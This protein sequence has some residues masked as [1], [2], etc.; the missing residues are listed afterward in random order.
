MVFSIQ[1]HQYKCK[2]FRYFVLFK[3]LV[4]DTNTLFTSR[5]ILCIDS[6]TF[7]FLHFQKTGYKN[8]PHNLWKHSQL[9]IKLIKALK[10]H[11][12]SEV[13][14]DTRQVVFNRWTTVIINFYTLL[15]SFA[16]TKSG[17]RNAFY[18][19]ARK[20]FGQYFLNWHKSCILHLHFISTQVQIWGSFAISSNE[21][22]TDVRVHI[23]RTF[24]HLLTH[25]PTR[26]FSL[27]LGN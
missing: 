21:W 4:S 7:N 2:I 12:Y 10:D 17:K 18:F 9:A 26:C 14:L 6:D 19:Y 20:Y 8:S 5:Y 13:K 1:K 24:M 3:V 27:F 16:G 11:L 25:K 22:V 15:I 23:F